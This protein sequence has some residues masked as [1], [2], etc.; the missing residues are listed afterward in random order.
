MREELLTAFLA[1]EAEPRLRDKLTF[2]LVG[3]NGYKH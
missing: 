2:Y 3:D 1:A